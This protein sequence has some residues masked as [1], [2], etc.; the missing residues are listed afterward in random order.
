[1][2][3]QD[4]E[5]KKLIEKAETKKKEVLGYF[6]IDDFITPDVI[7]EV[8]VEDVGRIRFKR[9]T[10]EDLW[11]IKD[12]KNDGEYTARLIVKMMAKAD[13]EITLDKFRRLPPRIGSA[14]LAALSG[15]TGFLKEPEGS[16]DGSASPLKPKISG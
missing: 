3:L 1:M 5:V 12:W 11:D 9:L 14:I 7:E 15:K 13:S 2:A 6:K 16:S 8:Y 10:T 4:P